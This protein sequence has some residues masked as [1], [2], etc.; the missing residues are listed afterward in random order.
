MVDGNE[1]ERSMYGVIK[2]LNNGEI[3]HLYIYVY[4]K[5]QRN[6]RLS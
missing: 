6:W 1:M 5:G 3:S 2:K 4:D